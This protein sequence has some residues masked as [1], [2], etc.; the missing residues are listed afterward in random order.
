MTLSFHTLEA[1]RSL[2]SSTAQIDSGQDCARPAILIHFFQKWIR[3]GL[4]FSDRSSLKLAISKFWPDAPHALRRL[5]YRREVSGLREQ[6]S[7]TGNRLLAC[8]SPIEQ[9][10]E[11]CGP[12]VPNG[13]S[14]E[15]LDA[16]ILSNSMYCYYRLASCRGR[17][18]R[19]SYRNSHCRYEKP[20]RF[21]VW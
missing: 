20:D 14:K 9:N 1:L 3:L 4:S 5:N 12:G 19:W 16:T 18:S 7:S 2:L 11:K 15:G 10:Y 8:W 17:F 13:L 21:G 6:A